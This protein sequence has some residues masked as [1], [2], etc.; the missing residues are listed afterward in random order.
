MPNYYDCDENNNI[1][2]IQQLS[3]L[4]YQLGWCIIKC[5]QNNESKEMQN[6]SQ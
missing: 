5:N 6:I 2:G 1:L 4:S 3:F